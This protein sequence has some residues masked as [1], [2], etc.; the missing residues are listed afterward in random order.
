MLGWEEIAWVMEHI[1][2]YNNNRTGTHSLNRPCPTLMPILSTHFK[3]EI[4]EENQEKSK[5]SHWHRENILMHSVVMKIRSLEHH[6]STLTHF[7][8]LPFSFPLFLWIFFSNRF[9]QLPALWSKIN[10]FV[11]TESYEFNMMRCPR[12]G[13]GLDSGGGAVDDLFAFPKASSSL[14][15]LTN[16]HHPP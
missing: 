4:D 10:I 7:H 13:H 14:R 1:I 5:F 8:V 15:R 9:Q 3:P 6:F 16:K 2:V 12:Y 11:S